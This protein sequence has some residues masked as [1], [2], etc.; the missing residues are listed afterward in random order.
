MISSLDIPAAVYRFYAED[1]RPLYIGMTVNPELR[2][3]SHR[4]AAAWWRLV[5]MERTNITWF[6]TRAEAA[7]AEF[8]AIE[9]EKPEFNIVGIDGFRGGRPRTILDRAQEAAIEEVLES[10]QKARE[11]GERAWIAAQAAREVGVPDTVLCNRTGL[12]RATLN[13]K[14][15][16]RP[17]LTLG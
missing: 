14:F 11:A 12:N 1:G 9:A 10:A 16:A 13:R 6:D 5:D 3:S 7:A 15:G 2:F 17:K 4:H 8:S